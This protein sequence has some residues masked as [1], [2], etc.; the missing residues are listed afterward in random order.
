MKL[1]DAEEVREALLSRYSNKE[2]VL[3]RLARGDFDPPKFSAEAVDL[4]KKDLR[5]LKTEFY[6]E[7]RDLCDH[8]ITYLDQLRESK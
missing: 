7:Y 2:E 1:I 6:K 5:T 8:L 4:L 3:E